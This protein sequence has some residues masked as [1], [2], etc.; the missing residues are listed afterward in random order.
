M[1]ASAR[2]EVFWR[3]SLPGI[4]TN[5]EGRIGAVNLVRTIA[6]HVEHPIL[7]LDVLSALIN[8]ESPMIELISDTDFLPLDF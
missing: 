2:L 6:R 3:R 7:E 8:D 1:L 4:I 5:H